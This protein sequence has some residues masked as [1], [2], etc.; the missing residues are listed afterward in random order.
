M[1]NVYPMLLRS[2]LLMDDFPRLDIE[3][4]ASLFRQIDP[5]I[6]IDLGEKG[7]QR[8]GRLGEAWSWFG[9]HREVE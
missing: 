8:E 9:R 7:P 6:G 5:C 2:Q 1:N 4:C 3:E